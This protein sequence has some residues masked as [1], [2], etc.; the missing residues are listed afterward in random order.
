MTTTIT[1]QALVI[2][3]KPETC[4]AVKRALSRLG[5]SVTAAQTCDRA[6]DECVK[7]SFDIVLVSLCVRGTGARSFSR[8]V[9]TRNPEAKVFLLTSWEGALDEKVLASEGISGV[10]HKPPR[11]SEIRRTLIDNLG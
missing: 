10:I 6:A 2:D 9:R 7:K 8:W 1:F 3:D 5:C 11:F 4:N